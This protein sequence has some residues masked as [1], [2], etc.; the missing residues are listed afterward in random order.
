MTTARRAAAI[1]GALI[2][3]LA[4]G[5][6]TMAAGRCPGALALDCP[7]ALAPAVAQTPAVDDTKRAPELSGQVVGDVA[8][9]GY[10]SAT[11]GIMVKVE[12]RAAA[13]HLRVVEGETPIGSVKLQDGVAVYTLPDDLPVGKH[14]LRLVFEPSEATEAT[15]EQAVWTYDVK[16]KQ[17]SAKRAKQLGTA[18]CAAVRRLA[19]AKVATIRGTQEANRSAYRSYTKV[20]AADTSRKGQR[21]WKFL[22]DAGPGVRLAKVTS[23]SVY[24]KYRDFKPSTAQQYETKAIGNC[25]G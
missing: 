5:T 16:V 6:P 25:V 4:G 10:S 3:L 1:G 20:S 14:E 24:L 13:G 19:Q 17:P 22:R 9:H 8:Y 21:Y 7:A 12:G 11:F 23:S 18:Y 2:V 15:V